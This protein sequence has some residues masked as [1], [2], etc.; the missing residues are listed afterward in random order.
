LEYFKV[1]P[2]GFTNSPAHMQ[3]FM[4]LTPVLGQFV[5]DDI[6]KFVK[7]LYEA[8]GMRCFLLSPKFVSN[9]N[10]AHPLPNATIER[11]T[12]EPQRRRAVCTH[13]LDTFLM[14]S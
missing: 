2:F 6:A 3:R 5:A 12:Q 11:L 1:V 4:H 13:F 9:C 10:I 8:A 7:K 14:I